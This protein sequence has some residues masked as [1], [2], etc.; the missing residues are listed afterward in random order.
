MSDSPSELQEAQT[1][2]TRAILTARE[3]ERIIALRHQDHGLASISRITGLNYRTVQ[4]VIRKYN[5]TR[6][7]S[8][9]QRGRQSGDR[10]LT[11]EVI[12]FVENEIRLECTITLKTIQ[13]RIH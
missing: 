10:L 7:I 11:E 3:K 6:E 8:T 9:G 5:N 1:R 4:A 12:R 13:T 2:R